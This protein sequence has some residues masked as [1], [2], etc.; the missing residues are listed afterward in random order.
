M[1][2]GYARVSTE[3]QRANLQLDALKRAGCAV[4]FE[5]SASGACSNRPVLKEV[6]RTLRAGDTLITWRLD[7]LGRSLSHLI[8]VVSDLEVRGVAFRSLTEAID[9]SSSGGRLLFHVMG[10]LAEIERSL[11]SERTK[12]GMAAARSRGAAIGRPRSS[13]KWL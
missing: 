1:L 10:A 5:E 2:I 12:A 9:T 11:I 3:D 13:R 6:L 7:R 4:V 8:G